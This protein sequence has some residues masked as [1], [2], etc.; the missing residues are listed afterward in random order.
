MMSSKTAFAHPANYSKGFPLNAAHE[1]LCSLSGNSLNDA[2][3]AEGTPF[4]IPVPSDPGATTSV[5]LMYLYAVFGL[6]QYALC[7]I[8]DKESPANVL[9]IALPDRKECSEN[10][11]F[12]PLHGHTVSAWRTSLP[13]KWVKY[14]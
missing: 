7:I 8:V 2:N 10:L 11:E 9:E 14:L 13:L 3:L 6:F 12:L 1:L 5:S 4:T